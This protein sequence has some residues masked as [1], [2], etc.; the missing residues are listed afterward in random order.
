MSE[1]RSPDTSQER[2]QEGGA[3]PNPEEAKAASLQ[4]GSMTPQAY[5]RTN[6]ICVLSLLVVWFLVSYGCG[7][8]WADKLD[9]M[10]TPGG[11]IKLGFWFA[12]QGSIF[13]FVVLIAFYVWF[14]NRLD[15]K[16]NGKKG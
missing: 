8:L 15:A 13:V 4:F 11:G 10:R 6:I 2:P 12:Q 9:E 1:N 3:E 5:W 14:M 16:F 7:I